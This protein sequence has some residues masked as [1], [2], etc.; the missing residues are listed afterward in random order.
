MN[1]LIAIT[2]LLKKQYNKSPIFLLAIASLLLSTLVTFTL[3][4]IKTPIQTTPL[5]SSQ[6]IPVSITTIK[7]QSNPIILHTYGTVQAEKQVVLTSPFSGKVESVGDLY[8]GKAFLANEPLFKLETKTLDHAIEQ[9]NIQ[10]EKNK[11]QLLFLEE[12]KLLTK[13]R[14][15]N[16]KELLKTSQSLLDKQITTLNIE[17]KLFLKQK[18]LFKKG[19]VSNTELLESE[20]QLRK[21]ELSVLQAKTSLE[22]TQDNLQQLKL[23]L[24]NNKINISKLNYEQKDLENKNIELKKD[25]RKTNI[26]VDFPSRIT[27][28]F[29]DKEQETST[30]TQLATVISTN[31]VEIQAPV[32]DHLFKWLYKGGLLNQQGKEE[33]FKRTPITIRLV[34]QGLNTTYSN[35]L[36]KEFGESVSEETRSL[37]VIIQRTNPKDPKGNPLPEKELKPGMFCAISFP[38]CFLENTYLIPESALQKE[39]Q[40]Y[41]ADEDTEGSYQLL[42]I[43]D[44]TVLFNGEEGLIITA[45]SLKFK[46]NKA[47]K[48]INHPL[49][50]VKEED[51]LII[52]EPKT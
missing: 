39:N 16:A 30:G 2:A 43:K 26:S 21:E 4:K 23:T 49:E 12:E 46:K 5:L 40:I 17:K 1:P 6:N 48:L 52:Q 8:E 50:Y 24:L 15:E 3:I 31:T 34:N 7:K 37:P 20:T 36:I 9:L 33:L 47:L 41:L 28:L 29:I 27:E 25:L 35:G 22:S 51:S 38:L 18:E 44:V 42:I 10:V 13:K 14:V 11:T 32:Y 19:T 45:P